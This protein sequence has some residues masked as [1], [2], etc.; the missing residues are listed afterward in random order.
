M[1]FLRTLKLA[2]Y[3][4]LTLLALSVI[5]VYRF[6][7]IQQAWVTVIVLYSGLP[8]YHADKLHVGDVEKNASGKKI[9]EIIRVQSYEILG[10]RTTRD[11]LFEVKVLAEVNSKSGEHEFKNKPLKTGGI[12]ELSLTRAQIQLGRIVEVGSSY[13]Y[14]KVVPK[15]VTFR[16]YQQVPWLGEKISPG[17]ASVASDGEKIIEVI[18]KEVSPAEITT[19]T[20]TGQTVKTTDPLKVDIILKARVNTRFFFG[21]PFIQR[22]AKIAIGEQL[23]FTVGK[24]SVNDA[25]IVDVE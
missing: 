21:E 22:D 19:T 20:A 3:I 5:V 4:I 15:I 9:A 18:S 6:F 10:T 17:D 12:I 11:M 24:T 8:N 1:R 16:L 2:D 7:H 23:S 14:K 25:W 13:Y